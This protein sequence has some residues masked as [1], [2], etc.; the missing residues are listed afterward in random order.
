MPTR[1]LY[2][3]L[4]EYK[5]KPPNKEDPKEK[6]IQ[7]DLGL[8]R[9][10]LASVLLTT[11]NR[12][13]L[14]QTA[15]ESVCK[16]KCGD[17]ELFVLDDNSND[18]TE[19]YVKSLSDRRIIYYNSYI[20]ESE[21]FSTCRYSVML[22]TAMRKS[23]GQYIFYLTDDCYYLPTKIGTCIDYLRKTGNGVSYNKQNILVEDERYKG[24]VPSIREFVDPFDKKRLLN[25]NYIDHN[26]LV[27]VRKCWERVG[28]WPEESKYWLN[29]D[30]YYLK[31]LAKYYQFTAIPIVLDVFRLHRGCLN[32]RYITTKAQQHVRNAQQTGKV[33][34]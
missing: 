18:G 33:N 29:A 13:R 31:Q 2:R 34:E 32:N 21:R 14:L 16:Q 4:R 20:S 6:S 23:R 8:R 12:K 24:Q 9:A 11:Y 25:K 30:W 1:G 17:L 19:Q 7:E 5:Y 27:H 3:H 26:S 22:N 10:P 15:I 28:G